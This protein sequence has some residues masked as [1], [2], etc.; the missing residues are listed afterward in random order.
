MISFENAIAVAKSNAVSLLENAQNFA[1]E[2]V[3]LSED[4]KLYEVSL[5][6]DTQG[7]DIF[8]QDIKLTENSGLLRL[9]KIMGYRKE[10]K[11]FLVD[12]K[13]GKFRGFKNQKDH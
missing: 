10:F 11:V 13:N 1:L 8:S 2:G 9:A 6:Y 3:L 7:K 5:S 12:S 4:S